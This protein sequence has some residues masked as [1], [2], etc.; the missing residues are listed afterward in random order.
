MPDDVTDSRLA[1]I[2]TKLAVV[3]ALLGVI[4]LLIGGLC[5]QGFTIIGRLPR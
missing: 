5:W 1:A 3:H 4:I 2:D